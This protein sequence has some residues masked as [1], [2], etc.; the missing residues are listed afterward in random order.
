MADTEAGLLPGEHL[1]WTGRPV[2][3]RVIPGDLIYPGLLLVALLAA[4]TL[5]VPRGP[6]DAPTGLG[7]TVLG[8]RLRWPG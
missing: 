2:R 5:G 8:G 3:A 6:A 1:L 4:L 7:L